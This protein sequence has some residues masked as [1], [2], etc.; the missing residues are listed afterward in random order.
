MTWL[1]RRLACA[2]LLVSFA[3]TVTACE[4][5]RERVEKTAEDI[6]D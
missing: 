2:M 1:V 4:N 6:F 5:A 3:V